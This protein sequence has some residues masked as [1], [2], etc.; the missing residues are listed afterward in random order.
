M[1][2]TTTSDAE[3]E[4]RTRAAFDRFYDLM[5]RSDPRRT[6]VDSAWT[7]RDVAAHVLDVLGRYTR[8]D[9]TVPD[10]LA[11]TPFEVGDLN[12][13]DLARREGASVPDLLGLLKSELEAYLALEIPLDAR[14]PF[15]T[16]QTIDGA[17][18][19]GNMLGELL[20]HGWDVARTMKQPWPIAARD[21]VL[22][23][24]GGLQVASGWLDPT[25]T[26]GMQFRARIHVAG[27]RSQLMSIDDG[28]C[29]VAD[30]SASDGPVDVV[31]WARAVPID[32]LFLKR[33]GLPGA[34]RRG[35]AV[36]GGRRPWLG[37]QLPRLFLPV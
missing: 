4:A 33:I 2:L 15:H 22:H 6:L 36:V 5:A 9:L 13:R 30:A 8:R 26:A 24:N 20:V 27:G 34:I 37:L 19:R 12:A 31:V 1:T 35:L 14:F 3:L 7:C 29:T 28:A 11:E 25:A 23:V 17:G 16:G 10:G 32:L 18:A 21:A